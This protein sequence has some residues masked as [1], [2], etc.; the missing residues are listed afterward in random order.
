EERRDRSER[1]ADAARGPR[2]ERLRERAAPQEL[3]D[4]LEGEP[5]GEIGREVTAI[6]RTPRVDG[7]QPR[8]EH[9]LAPAQ[10]ARGDRPVTRARAV[11][12]LEPLDVLAKVQALPS[13]P[14]GGLAPDEA[15]A[16]VGVEGLALHP[17]ELRGFAPGHVR[18][19]LGRDGLIAESTLINHRRDPTL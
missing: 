2:R 17:Q 8:L 15:A 13:P 6:P 9:R 14:A 16:R 11:A 18:R 19:R 10:R 7:R 12:R 3:R 1:Y 5:L 4:G